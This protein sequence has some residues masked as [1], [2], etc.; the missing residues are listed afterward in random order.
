MISCG[1]ID[2]LYNK[3][4]V[5][6]DK[7]N[8]LTGKISIDGLLTFNTYTL[9]FGTIDLGSTPIKTIHIDNEYLSN[10][11]LALDS[12]MM[13][14]PI[15]LI[16]N[17]CINVLYKQSCDIVVQIEATK[18]GNIDINQSIK[19]NGISLNII[20]Q[21][22]TP[23]Q[24]SI[25][26][27]ND[28]VPPVVSPQDPPIDNVIINNPVPEIPVMAILPSN[29]I[30]EYGKLL[31]Y[32]KY[33]AIFKVTNKSIK[34][35]LPVVKAILPETI[36][37]EIQGCNINL[38]PNE[39]CNIEVLIDPSYMSLGQ[40]SLEISINDVVKT[41]NFELYHWSKRHRIID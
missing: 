11:T 6:V 17:T 15:S 24:G 28:P 19:I 4:S 33:K 27:T 10:L 30:F 8:N 40:Y 38:L 5:Q 12:S 20:G 23:V 9:N 22:L 1:K 39:S 18:T 3:L 26:V 37:V 31:D 16:S 34:V 21:I 2:E 13:T 7:I 14:A 32:F 25:P 29:S 35:E 36:G 41:I